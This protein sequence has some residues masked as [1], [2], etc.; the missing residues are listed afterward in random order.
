[1]VQE[2]EEIYIGVT[3]WGFLKE[4]G[5]E[6]KPEIRLDSMAEKRLSR[7]GELEDEKER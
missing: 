5:R 2:W 7:K 4:K 1:M 6:G 3:L